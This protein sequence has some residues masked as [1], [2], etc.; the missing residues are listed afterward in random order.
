MQLQRIL[1]ADARAA[2]EQALARFGPDVL[3]VSTARVGERTELIVAVDLTEAP[4]RPPAPAP[5]AAARFQSMLMAQPAPAPHDMPAAEGWAEPAWARLP[6]MPVPAA[7]SVAPS[8]DLY[9]ALHP[10][11]SRQPGGDRR[12][13]SSEAEGTQALV[14]AIRDDLAALRRELRRAAP[15]GGLLGHGAARWS[16]ELADA[17][18]PL[19]LRTLL[20]EA[21][22]RLDD[23]RQAADAP[24]ADTAAVAAA[25]RD[26]LHPHLPAPA[27][28]PLAPGLHLLAGPPGA[29]KTLMA[30]RWARRAVAR[31]G[32]DRVT[33]VGWYDGR[34]GAW[35]QLQ[36]LGARLGVETLRANDA[37]TLA[38]LLDDLPADRLLLVDTSAPLLRGPDAHPA[39]QPAADGATPAAD[40]ARWPGGRGRSAP[41]WHLVLPA[42]ASATLVQRWAP[43]PPAGWAGLWIS[44]LDAGLEPWSLLQLACEAGLPVMAASQGDDLDALDTRFDAAALLHLATQALAERLDAPLAAPATLALAAPRPARAAAAKA[45]APEKP[46]TPAGVDVPQFVPSARPVDP[47]PAA[48]RRARSTRL[49][50]A[51]QRATTAAGRVPVLAD[52]APRASEVG[53]SPLFGAGPADISVDG[54]SAGA[55]SRARSTASTLSKASHA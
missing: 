20:A 54:A 14:S 43:A 21:R 18:V 22:V 29:G 47:A 24:A 12:Q 45:I 16:T 32:A 25:L 2:K 42:D 31:L 27:E 30:A 28:L 1:A 11:A 15:A 33:L 48:A 46:T 51:A 40:A 5:E 26:S 7:P 52:L 49:N 44:R 4:P 37:A 55:S 50:A 9:A 38:L 53:P 23:D 8:A 35:G 10:A 36:L 34:A 39:T 19:R 3:I 13:H 6:A 17:G 41:C